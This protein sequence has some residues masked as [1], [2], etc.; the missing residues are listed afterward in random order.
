MLKFTEEHEWLKLDGDEVRPLRVL[1]FSVCLRVF[2]G[3]KKA[4]EDGES[5]RR[6][7]H[8]FLKTQFF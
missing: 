8:D 2:H 3:E 5:C 1:T 4:Q 7:P 6:H